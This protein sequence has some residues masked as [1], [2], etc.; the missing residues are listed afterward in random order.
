MYMDYGSSTTRTH[1]NL[2]NNAWKDIGLT[3]GGAVGGWAVRG[4]GESM[5]REGADLRRKAT[6]TFDGKFRGAKG[7]FAS[8]TTPGRTRVLTKEGGKLFAKGKAKSVAGKGIYN[9]GKKMTSIANIMGWAS[10][11]NMGFHMASSALSSGQAFKTTKEEL[12]R[13]NFNAS[14]DQDTYYDTRAA[15]TQRQRALQVIHNS[16]LSLKPMLGS[17]SNFLHY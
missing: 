17:E 4:A 6:K 15:Y 9:Y 8:S 2:F 5:R 7:Q 11:A 3:L 10:L 14:N 16:R 13:K 12:A 1:D